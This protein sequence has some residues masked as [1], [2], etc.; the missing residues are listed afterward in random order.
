MPCAPFFVFPRYYPPHHPSLHL[1]GYIGQ[2]EIRHDG[3]PHSTSSAIS[4]SVRYVM[5]A[6][7]SG[8]SLIRDSILAPPVATDS[9]SRTAIRQT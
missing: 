6:G 2:R 5:M 1:V 3:R 8:R 9:C 4:A 7:G